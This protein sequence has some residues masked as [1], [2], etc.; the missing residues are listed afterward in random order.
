[1]YRGKLTDRD[2]LHIGGK[3]AVEYISFV[4]VLSRN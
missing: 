3:L 2:A 1:M 4:P